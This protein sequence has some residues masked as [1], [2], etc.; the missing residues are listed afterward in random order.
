MNRSTSIAVVIVLV[1]LAAFVFLGKNTTVK[2]T[3]Q[4]SVHV[5]LKESGFDPREVTIIQGGT[6]T[7][8]STMG[9]PYRPASNLHPTHGLYPDFDPRRPL[10]PEEEWSF[11]FDR[12]GEHNFHDHIRSYFV[13]VIHVVE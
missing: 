1:G 10:E 5:V 8:S 6:V 4:T 11:T 2:Q 13:G 12:L 9:K 7:F 3:V